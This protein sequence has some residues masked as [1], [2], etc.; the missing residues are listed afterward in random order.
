MSVHILGF[1]SGIST[2]APLSMA[3]LSLSHNV[4]EQLRTFY[5]YCTLSSLDFYFFGRIFLVFFLFELF[6][7]LRVQTPESAHSPTSPL[8]L[9]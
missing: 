3:I 1:S 9:H 8:I 4:G 2:I 5:F 6:F 7:Y